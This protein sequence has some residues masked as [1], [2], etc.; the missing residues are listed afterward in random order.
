MTDYETMTGDEYAF[1]M[2]VPDNWDSYQNGMSLRD[3]FAGLALQGLIARSSGIRLADADVLARG[4]YA[5]ADA[6]LAE[7]VKK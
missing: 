5:I 6:M 7:R 1:P 2:A 3:H 4:S